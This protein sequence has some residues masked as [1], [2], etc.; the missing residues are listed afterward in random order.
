MK[1][2]TVLDIKELI[3]SKNPRLAKLLPFFVIRYFRRILHEKELNNFFKKIKIFKIK[4]SV[5]NY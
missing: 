5:Q 4:N 3:K 1:E 2:A